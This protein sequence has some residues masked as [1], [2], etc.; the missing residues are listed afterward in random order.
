MPGPMAFVVAL[1]AP[2][3]VSL[4]GTTLPL[5]VAA[6]ALSRVATVSFALLPRP[7]P[8]PMNVAAANAAVESRMR[9]SGSRFVEVPSE[10]PL[11]AQG[12][13]RRSLDRPEPRRSFSRAFISTPLPGVI[14]ATYRP[15]V[16]HSAHAPCA[17]PPGGSPGETCLGRAI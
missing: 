8:A 5:A 12:V 14:H 2:R 1:M 4:A 16:P 6:A 17:E 10:T 3:V 13:C 11:R 15:A 7:Q 9:M